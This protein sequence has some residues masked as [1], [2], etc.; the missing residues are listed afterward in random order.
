MPEFEAEYSLGSRSWSAALLEDIAY[1]LE[2]EEGI[3]PPNTPKIRVQV[4]ILEEDYRE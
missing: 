3:R 2:V 4:E 1:Y